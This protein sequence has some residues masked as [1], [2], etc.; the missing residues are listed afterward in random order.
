MIVPGFIARR[1]GWDRTAHVQR[2]S[3]AGECSGPPSFDV[4]P[5]VVSS[6]L[7]SLAENRRR[8][9]FTKV[10]IDVYPA[11]LAVSEK[12]K[13]TPSPLLWALNHSPRNRIAV[14]IPQFL[15][16][17]LATPSIEVVES[18]CQT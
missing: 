17:P 1:E 16:V 18:G 7:L 8:L 6:L 3:A 4:H 2:A 12:S 15:H 5:D 11:F 13:A 10:V 14:Q 9:R